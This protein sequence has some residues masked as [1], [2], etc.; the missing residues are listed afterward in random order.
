[1]LL[2]KIINNNILE[3]ENRK[4]IYNKSE[5]DVTYSIM[6]TFNYDNNLNKVREYVLKLADKKEADKNI[7]TLILNN[8]NYTKELL[9]SIKEIINFE[10]DLLDIIKKITNISKEYKVELI[11][12]KNYKAIE[13]KYTQNYTKKT[14]NKREEDVSD[15]NND[16]YKLNIN[17]INNIPVYKIIEILASKDIISIVDDLKK[18]GRKE[19]FYKFIINN[20][21]TRRTEDN[22]KVSVTSQQYLDNSPDDIDARSLYS[23]VKFILG[24]GRKG[25]KGTIS[26]IQDLEELGAF[27]EPLSK[28]NSDNEEE[29]KIYNKERFSKALKIINR[30]ILN[31]LSENLDNFKIDPNKISAGK[32][33]IEAFPVRHPIKDNKEIDKYRDFLVNVRKLDIDIVEEEIKAGRIF[34]GS[35][36]N[37]ENKY[38]KNL[39]FS[40]YDHNFYRTPSSFEICYLSKI[41]DEDTKEEKEKINKMFFKDKSRKGLLYGKKREDAEI[42]VFSEAVIDSI[43][44]ECLTK[45][46]KIMKDKKFN[47]ISA[48]GSGNL[49]VWFEN[50]LGFGFVHSDNEVP[51]N[52]GNIYL[53]DK[54]DNEKEISEENK[55]NLANQIKD[56]KITF[57]FDESERNIK[58]SERNLFKLNKFVQF[59]DPSISVDII[60]VGKRGAFLDKAQIEGRYLIDN[61]NIEDFIIENNFKMEYIKEEKNYKVSSFYTHYK[62]TPIDHNDVNML[63]EL[64]ERIIK[65]IGTDTLYLA[66]D[67]DTGGLNYYEGFYKMC[68]HLG[69][70]VSLFIPPFNNNINDNNDIL[71]H[72]KGI[73]KRFSEEQCSIWLDSN[74]FSQVNEDL[75]LNGYLKKAIEK[76][77]YIKKISNETKIDKKKDNSKQP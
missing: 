51:E 15:N 68:K 49:L 75:Y 62:N 65:V 60:K 74:Y 19:V 10:K 23:D 39:F 24:S 36:L 54:I 13:N 5:I 7:F 41:V 29:L 31:N 70:N 25:G 66:Y 18:N 53:V 59:F 50:V 55:L 48:Q 57:I 64:R 69:I 3:K 14:G 46:S 37:E 67:N 56:L 8:K 73:S 40:Q 76:A 11:L 42:T 45:K 28:P 21:E 12:D 20:E 2:E 33:K 63:K 32:L 9:D 6:E 44:F 35:Y 38:F 71:K 26:F 17:E 22:M 30:E 34:S 47:F 4:L 77:L 43:S 61:T 52:V 58:S 1:M 27:G 72:F 16:K